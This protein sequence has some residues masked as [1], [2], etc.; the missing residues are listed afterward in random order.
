MLNASYSLMVARMV[1]LFSVHALLIA[2][3]TT[4]VHSQITRLTDPMLC[5]VCMRMQ[6]FLCTK[7]LKMDSILAMIM[8]LYS[9]THSNYCK[10]K[11]NLKTQT[12][13]TK[14]RLKMKVGRR[15]STAKMGF[16]GTVFSSL[17]LASSL[18]PGI[19]HL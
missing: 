14:N 2:S 17:S 15:Y 10:Q 19:T 11:T 16:F 4:S 3:H 12:R 13:L 6:C 5:T 1:A 18:N 8:L 9:Y 7:M